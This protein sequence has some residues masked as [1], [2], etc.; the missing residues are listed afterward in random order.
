MAFVFQP[1]FTGIFFKILANGKSWVICVLGAV[2]AL[3]PDFLYR[4]VKFMYFPSKSEKI[5]NYVN[6]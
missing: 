2:I 1:E 4:I 6:L 5:I 3:I